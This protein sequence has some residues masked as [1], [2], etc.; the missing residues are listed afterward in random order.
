MKTLTTSRRMS[1]F[2]LLDVMITVAVIS[3]A[4]LSL[5]G[6]HT[7][8]IKSSSMSKTRAIAASVAQAK[9]DDL[10]AFQEL[11]GADAS[12]AAIFGYDEIANNDGGEEDATTEAPLIPSGTVALSDNN[13]SYN[14]TWTST[15]YYYCAAD[16]VPTTT[17]PSGC[18]KSRPDFKLLMVSVTWEDPAEPGVTQTYNLEG[19][20]SAIAPSSSG[21]AGGSGGEFAKPIQSTAARDKDIDTDGSDDASIGSS[22]IDVD[23]SNQGS[24]TI[25]TFEQVTYNN[26][27]N[28]VGEVLT[29][30]SLLTVNCICQFVG[31]AEGYKPTYFDVEQDDYVV[32][33]K[34]TKMTGQA[35]GGS[36]GGQPAVCDTCCR[37]HHDS[38][39][40]TSGTHS[41][42]NEV[43]DPFRSTTDYVDGNHKHYYDTSNNNTT[44]AEVTQTPGNNYY[45]ACKMTRVDGFLRVV[46]DWKLESLQAIPS[47]GLNSTTEISEYTDYV[48]AFIEDYILNISNNYPQT[49]PSP[50]IS[51]TA[52]DWTSAAPYSMINGADE[53]FEARGLYLDYIS[54]TLLNILKCKING[55]GSD[56]SDIPEDSGYLAY[57]P[58]YEVDL[59]RL[60]SWST[61]VNTPSDGV[62]STVDTTDGN[63][64]SDSITQNNESTYVRGR[65]HVLEDGH[66][67]VR[68]TI[69][70]SNTG[71]LP[72]QAPIDD[73][74]ATN[75]DNLTLSD[76]IY[77]NPVNA[78]VKL[79][80]SGTITATINSTKLQGPESLS[81]VGSNGASC[82]N[83]VAGN[84]NTATYSCS[85]DSDGGTITFGN[86]TGT[87]ESCTGSGQSKVCT[88]A[89]NYDNCLAPSS[90]TSASAGGTDGTSTETASYV[91]TGITADTTFSISV[92]H[93]PD[94]SCSP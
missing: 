26:V 89:V 17:I 87:T 29:R 8:I 16:A 60:A 5:G 6:L 2:G 75:P 94:N 66:A 27:V 32:G 37:D 67:H 92:K 57:V 24:N 13:V 78:T 90:S 55:S 34:V 73:K 41:S 52:F 91:F 7:L 64:F 93:E 38:A 42:F 1:G 11:S 62:G 33:E 69:K 68:A 65:V 80:I 20:V 84:G 31:E 12:T 23:L 14:L 10:R 21:L 63:G 71:L 76:D 25:A 83:P 35:A 3:I 15:G 81:V 85:L 74:A 49:T 61:I 50:T 47:L 36:F 46:Q 70:R 54:P 56:C 4:L 39:A 45:E 51:T 30:E 40:P 88:Y 22:D 59:T 44:L 48:K 28:G 79:K 53:N 18:T 43:Y 77:I 58:F 72:P 82:T 9:L 19:T 86:F